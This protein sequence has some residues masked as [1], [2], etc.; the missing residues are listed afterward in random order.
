M[1][2]CLAVLL[3]GVC[4]SVA[5]A[6]MSGASPAASSTHTWKF[7]PT[8]NAPWAQEDD[9]GSLDTPQAAAGLCRSTPFST[10]GAYGAL[11]TNVD[12][13]VG[14]ATNNSGFSNRG[15][16][17]PQ[18]E[19]TIAANPTN[20]NNLI[21]G[22]ND[23][24]V[25]CDFT[26]LND[27]SGWAYFSFNG[28]ATWGNVQLPGLTAETGGAGVFKKFDSAGDPAVTFSPD[29]VAYY[30][31]IVFSRVSFAS[32]VAVSVSRDGGKT[33]SDPNLVAFVDAGNF[34]NDKE[35][36][37]AGPDGKV[38]VTWTRFSLGPKGAGYLT[39]PIVS[40]FSKDEGKT[41]N[42]QSFPV[43]D[44]AH[45]FDQGS[46]V[47]YGPDGA[48]YVSYEAASPSTGYATD[49]MVIA[50]STDDGQTFQTKELARVFDD[51]NCYPVFGG[52]Q[53]LSDMHFRLNSYP[54]M[55]VDPVTGEISIAWTD[56]Q[57]SGSCGTSATS[58]SGTTSN[59]VKLIHAPWASI[60]SAAVVHVTSTAPDK[61]FPSV[62][63]RN[64]KIAV[65]YY[66]RDYAISSAAPVCH[67]KTNNAGGSNITPSP[68]VNSVCLDYAGKTS[69][70]GFS[71]QTR[72]STESSN[73]FVQFANGAFIGDYSQVALGA[74]GVAHA[75][76]TDFRG[77]PGVTSANQDVM[78]QN[79]T[80]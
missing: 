41:W 1:R 7:D 63:S 20:A 29:G 61:V 55:S 47:R 6:A 79:Y 50:R 36:I 27:A 67:V 72:L 13:I 16:T 59:Q 76:W 75:S 30:A 33:W 12:A 44:N 10:T 28:G 65:T 32:G 60:G 19:T 58:F 22:A 14:D 4:A 54:S 68:S 17:T 77:N 3:V 56:Q 64:G 66:T 42:R 2:R 51:N 8:I 53:T 48:L 15:C 73:P 35:W 23:Y 62:A 37:A 43:S 70:N 38:V 45:P 40:A 34:F 71:T 11:G 46:Q 26:G 21:A 24:R 49:A 74:N 39:S 31:N 9:Q 78:I 5:F 18:N 80:P 69:S 52:R 57:G 25:C